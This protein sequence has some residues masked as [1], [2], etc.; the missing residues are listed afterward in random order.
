M[1]PHTS[2]HFRKVFAYSKTLLWF[3]KGDRL[4]EGIPPEYMPNFIVSTTPEKLL[5]NKGWGQSPAEAE[6]VIRYLTFPNECVCDPMMG[7]G[8]TGK[9]AI[10]LGRQFIGCEI[11]REEYE[12]ADSNI[13][14]HI[15]NREESFQ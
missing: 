15:K 1:G 4:R 13:K 8:T 3:V 2:V 5:H 11:D 6:H 12:S 10:N 14:R 7:E 9:A